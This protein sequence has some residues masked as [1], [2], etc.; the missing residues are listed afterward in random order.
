MI[1]KLIPV[2]LVRVVVNV[3]KSHLSLSQLYTNCQID[4]NTKKCRRNDRNDK[5][6]DVIL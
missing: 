1:K 5:C 6:I 3:P 4:E 2:E